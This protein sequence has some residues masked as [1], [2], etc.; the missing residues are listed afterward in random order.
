MNN[1]ERLECLIGKDNLQKAQL[2]TVAVVGLGGVG[3]VCALTLARSGVGHLLIQDFDVVQETNINRQIIANY[4]SLGQKKTKLIEEE[5]KKINPQCQVT[6]LDERFDEHS[7][8]FSHSF[9]YL[10][11]AI[12]S[13]SD[14]YL[15]IKTCLQH[16]IPLISAMGT[17]KKMDLQKLSVLE[18]KKTTYDPL[19]K[20]IRKRLRDDGFIQTVIV[21]S[22]TEPIPALKE[23]G[24]YM[25][26]TSTAGLLLADYILKAIWKGNSQ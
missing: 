4:Q 19:A 16:G 17:A 23:L 1:F 18:I 26:V 2:A 5:I 22:S 13:V 15:L 7:S 8:L 14:K 24:S 12:D 11:D 20:I 9:D 25:P 21:V 6:V 3:G 10:V